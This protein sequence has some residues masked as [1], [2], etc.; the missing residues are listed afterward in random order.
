MERT[1]TLWSILRLYDVTSI[2]IPSFAHDPI[3]L[4]DVEIRISAVT[5]KTKLRSNPKLTSV[6]FRRHAASSSLCNV[7]TPYPG[8]G[9]S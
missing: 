9:A 4:I 7:V 8:R 1:I 6:N 5:E 3:V 2:R